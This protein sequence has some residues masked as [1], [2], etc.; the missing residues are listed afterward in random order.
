MRFYE[1]GP[2]LLDAHRLRLT[3]GGRLVPAG[4]KV[5]ETLLALAERAGEPV[6]KAALLARIWPDGFVDE[7]SLAQNVYV[8]RKTFR[9]HGVDPSIETVARVGYRLAPAVRPALAPASRRTSGA[10]VTVRRLAAAAA[11]A[12]VVAVLLAAGQTTTGRTHSAAMLSDDAQRLYTIGRYDWNLRTADSVEKSIAYFTQVVNQAPKSPLG[13]AALADANVTMGD[14]CYGVHR[15][16]Y[17][18]ARA[19]AYARLALALDPA[20]APA[21]ATLGFLLLHELRSNA[22]LSELQTAI[23]LDPSYAPAHEWLGIALLLRGDVSPAATQLGAAAALDPLSG[24]TSAWLGSTALAQG[25]YGDAIVY[26]KEAI[27][28]QPDRLTPLATIA[29]AYRAQGDGREAR[30]ADQRYARFVAGLHVSHGHPT[31]A[32]IESALRG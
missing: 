9:D 11:A 20:S 17:Y 15:P 14:Y 25:R 27:E 7:A 19:R 1:I 13:Y 10:R 23:A 28:L 3:C 24:S 12:F 22:A 21:H 29:E 18:F 30:I 26:S 5:V 16:A 2:F 8:L 32:S 6:A 4:P 31:W